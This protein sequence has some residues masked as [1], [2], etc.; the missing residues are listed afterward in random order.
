MQLSEINFGSLMTYTPRGGD[1][2]HRD[3]R[4]VMRM[5]KDDRVFPSGI[6]MSKTIAQIIKEGLGSYP[7]FSYFDRNTTLIPIPKSS[8]HK[9]GDL[10]I[11][12]RLTTA[13]SNEGLGK[14]E[15]CLVRKTSL[16]KS[17]TALAKNRPTALDH[18]RSMRIKNTLFEPKRITLIDDV[19][20]RGATSLGAA[21]RIME[22]FPDAEI[23][24]FAA[25]RTIS[26]SDEFSDVFDPCTGKILLRGDQTLRVP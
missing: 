24:V 20:T 22:V 6:L 3:S 1:S 15:A 8:L 14:S 4:S 17:A 23:R 11:P 10:W 13:L 5:L 18:Y 2:K 7:F 26:N 9:E 21:N 16:P 19:I 12:D 25:M